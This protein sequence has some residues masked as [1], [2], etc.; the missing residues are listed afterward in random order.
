MPGR[1]PMDAKLYQAEELRIARDPS[2]PSYL[3]PELRPAHRRILDLGCGAGQSLMA[4]PMEGRTGVGI[5]F[6]RSA[7]R[8][9]RSL[10]PDLLLVCGSGE[11]LPFRPGSFDL[12]FARVSLPYM[13]LDAALGEV[14]RT[15]KAE[16]DLWCSLHPF[17][18]TLGELRRHLAERQWRGALFRCAVMA[19]G[20]VLFLVGRQVPPRWVAGVRE[21]FQTRRGMKLL[22]LRLGY[23]S[24]RVGFTT[25]G[26]LVAEARWPRAPVG[27]G[28]RPTAA[29]R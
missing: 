28:P 22:L 14:A 26:F 17:R 15:L 9:G 24:V 2:H 12:V 16:S 4:L 5:D 20:L 18:L 25:A 27:S 29:F 11:A 21:T 1:A 23:Q 7:L 8:L 3:Q 10:R 13:D 19:N 6:D